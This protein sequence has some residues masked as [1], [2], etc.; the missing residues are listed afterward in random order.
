MNRRQFTYW[1]AQGLGWGVYTLLLMLGSLNFS[2]EREHMDKVLMLQVV[3]GACTF[4]GSHL[5]RNYIKRQNWV[6]A[7]L[8]KAIPR[9]LMLNLL[10][11]VG[12]IV[13]IHILMLTVLDWQSFRPIVWAEVPIYTFNIFMM[14]CVWAVFYFNF[15]YFEQT[16]K[17]TLEK[18]QAESAL[19]EAEL[20]AL[21]AQIN[22]H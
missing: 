3:I 2:V 17:A 9:M 10:A 14:Y 8:K 7:P 19:R 11:A 1:M 20:I 12:A 15:H 21:K 6:A 5:M 18:V 4:V 16:Q 22:P 13:V